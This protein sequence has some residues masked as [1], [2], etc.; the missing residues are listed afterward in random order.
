MAKTDL[1]LVGTLA[2]EMAVEVKKIEDINNLDLARW[3]IWNES[4]VRVRN[5]LAF[6]ESYNLSIY[7]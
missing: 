1:Y 5:S 3:H 2:G 4:P 7:I 6:L